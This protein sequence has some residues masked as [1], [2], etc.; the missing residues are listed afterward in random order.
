M[1]KIHVVFPLLCFAAVFTGGALE[2]QTVTVGPSG[3]LT[4]EYT[5]GRSDEG[6]RLLRGESFHTPS[7]SFA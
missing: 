5:P 2:A 3:Y 7:R 6:V 1:Q 4:A